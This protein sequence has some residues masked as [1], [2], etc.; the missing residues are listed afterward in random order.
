MRLKLVMVKSLIRLGS[1][2]EIPVSNVTRLARL[3]CTETQREIPSFHNDA[4][5]FC[6]LM[7]ILVFFVIYWLI[8]GNIY[9][10]VQ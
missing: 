4:H 2:L 5:Q 7:D 9:L 3:R 8:L 6:I 1:R 10:C